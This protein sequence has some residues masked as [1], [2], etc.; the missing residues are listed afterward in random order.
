MIQL[1]ISDLDL[2]KDN[3]IKR[4]KSFV[5]Q[6]KRSEMNIF[7]DGKNVAK[8]KSNNSISHLQKEDSKAILN[9]FSSVKKSI[10]KHLVDTDFKVKIVKKKY[11]STYS[12]KVLFD[13][14][15]NG[16]EF[17][18]ID[19]KH[20]YWRIAY[21]KGYISEY[22]YLKVLENPELK[23]FRN[24]ALSCIIAPKRVDYYEFGKFLWQIEEDTNIYNDIYESIRFTAWN[25]FGSLTFDKIGKEKTIGYFTDGIM[26]FK[27]D[28]PIVRMVLARQKLQYTIVKCTKVDYRMYYNEDTEDN[29][30]F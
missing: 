6:K 9:L 11:D 16:T 4:K 17:Y 13:E 26:I 7:L 12:N 27:E 15:P 22:F 21:L 28:I 20:C 25:I 29:R 3:L 30:K 2:Y 18:Y 5:V 10:N 19:V 14:L 23:I 8:F 1:N 24:M